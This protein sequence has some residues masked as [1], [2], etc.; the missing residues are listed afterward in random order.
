MT[1]P[2]LAPVGWAGAVCFPVAALGPSSG[3][4]SLSTRKTH[5]MSTVKRLGIRIFT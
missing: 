1:D 4:V 3:L 2:L 5:T